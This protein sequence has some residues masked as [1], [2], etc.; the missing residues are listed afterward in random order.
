[1]VDAPIANMLPISSTERVNP[2]NDMY[3]QWKMAS[4]NEREG[5]YRQFDALLQR[6]AERV[7]WMI[8]RRKDHQLVREMVN[9]LLIEI[10]TFAGRSKFS[11]WVHSR[12]R[13]RCIDELRWMRKNLGASLEQMQ[14]TGFQYAPTVEVGQDIENEMFVE[15][16]LQSLEPTDQTILRMRLAGADHTQIAKQMQCSSSTVFRELLRLEK[17]L[18][19]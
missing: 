10:D 7:V 19:E 11:T 3:D 12:F 17:Q 15:E 16:R 6:H 5:L 1:M 13:F 8:L 14:A 2:V 4:T 9:D 18:T